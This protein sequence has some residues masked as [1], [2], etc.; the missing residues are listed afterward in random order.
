MC[1][2]VIRRKFIALN[3]YI[4]KEGKYEN[5]TKLLSYFYHKKLEKEK[6]NK[7]RLSRRTE[8]IKILAE[9]SAIEDKQ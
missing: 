3:I 1:D 5:H 4:R 7:S 9:I 6:Q 8:R 2:A